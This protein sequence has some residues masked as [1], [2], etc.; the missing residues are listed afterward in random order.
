[1]TEAECKL[2]INAVEGLR[3]DLNSRMDS[4]SDVSNTRFTNL[5]TLMVENRQEMVS[6]INGKCESCE[7]APSFSA[8]L[9]EHW[10]HIVALWSAILFVGILAM[11]CS[12]YIFNQLNEH[13]LQ[14]ERPASI[15]PKEVK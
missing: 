7:N 10:W 3:A 5:Q 12:W 8:R 2:I 11:S 9:T 1:M 4:F 6:A 14:S 15:Q 13:R